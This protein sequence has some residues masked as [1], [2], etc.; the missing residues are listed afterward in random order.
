MAENGDFGGEKR[1]R[2]N[3]TITQQRNDDLVGLYEVTP[4]YSSEDIVAKQIGLQS[5]VSTLL[6]NKSELI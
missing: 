6:F 2:V 3:H 1:H 4:K 5:S